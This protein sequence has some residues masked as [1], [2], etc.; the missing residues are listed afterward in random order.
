[1]SGSVNKAKVEKRSKAAIWF[2]NVFRTKLEIESD[3]IQEMMEASNENEVRGN[4]TFYYSRGSLEKGLQA[5]LGA[6]PKYVTLSSLSVSYWCDVPLKLWNEFHE[7]SAFVSQLYNRV[8]VL[9]DK[10]V[11]EWSKRQI[12]WERLAAEADKK[13]DKA[14]VEEIKKE[15]EKDCV[16]LQKECKDVAVE[17]IGEFFTVKATTFANYKRYKFKV[18]CKLAFTFIGIAISIA[19]LSTAATPAAPATLVPAIIGLVAACA[20]AG[21]QIADLAASAEEIEAELRSGVS[22]IELDYKDKKGKAKKAK[23]AAKDLTSGFL[24][25][26]TGGMSDLVFPSVN[27]LMGLTGTHKSKLEG[28]AVTLHDMGINLN[29]LV[30]IMDSAGKVLDDNAKKLT[31]LLKTKP[32]DKDLKKFYDIVVKSG[33]VFTQLKTDFVKQ[34]E[35]DIPSMIKRVDAGMERNKT[36]EEALDKIEEAVGS[37]NWGLAGNL[38]AT[39]AL[40]AIGFSS[41]AP[42]NFAEK[43]TIGLAPAFTAVDTLREYTPDILEKIFG[44]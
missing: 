37:K 13:G 14:R 10:L 25:G 19:A 28:L 33:E 23:Y 18:G 41:G 35:K 16:A 24:S 29:G 9:T 32:T 21:K 42:S 11:K 22:T 2:N 43:V 6:P 8:N 34:F 17:D 36:L 1:M 12:H 20:S 15:F 4:T 40:T 26:L 27:G 31:E 7:D 44:K 30:T 39:I 5:L 38:F 3:K